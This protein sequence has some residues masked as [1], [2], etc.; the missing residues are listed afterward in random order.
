MDQYDIDFDH[1]NPP[2]R[3][4]LGAKYEMFTRFREA[5]LDEDS[6]NQHRSDLML[7][8]FLVDK[9]LE[10]VCLGFDSEFSESETRKLHIAAHRALFKKD[11]QTFST[12]AEPDK[13]LIAFDMWQ[14]KGKS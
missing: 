11:P 8:R 5:L 1:K 12:A 9:G 10:L 13:K 4:I 14:R 2:M 6:S 3:N 7:L